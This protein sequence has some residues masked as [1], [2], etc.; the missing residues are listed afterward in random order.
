MISRCAECGSDLKDVTLRQ[1]ERRGKQ[2]GL[3]IFEDVPAR[4]CPQCG[5]QY[6][7]AEVSEQMETVL[8]GQVHPTG[9]TT[10]ATFSLK[11]SGPAA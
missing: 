9:R 5:E 1:Y 11:M 7:S 2:V 8:S 6:F 3:V 10:I 4:E